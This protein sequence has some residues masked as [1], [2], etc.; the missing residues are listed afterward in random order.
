M[1]LKDEVTAASILG[2]IP[3]N[4]EPD[5]LTIAIV[6]AMR[7]QVAGYL[8]DISGTIFTGA[9][10]FINTAKFVCIG[11]AA[12]FAVIYAGANPDVNASFSP[13]GELKVSLSAMPKEIATFVSSTK[14]LC[15][16]G[17][18]LMMNINPGNVPTSNITV[19]EG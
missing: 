12:V 3:D 15:A 8:E 11:Y 9:T 6:E 1:A 13:D 18:E 19:A 4:L 5:D 14:K 17:F 2:R 7:D 16:P 10:P